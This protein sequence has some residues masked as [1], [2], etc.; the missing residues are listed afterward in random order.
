MSEWDPHTI[1]AKIEK[2]ARGEPLESEEG[3]MAWIRDKFSATDDQMDYWRRRT[4]A[5]GRDMDWLYV[6]CIAH[7]RDPDEVL[8]WHVPVDEEEKSP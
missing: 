6:A 4:A 2:V 7:G 8:S 5:A 1:A 3:Y